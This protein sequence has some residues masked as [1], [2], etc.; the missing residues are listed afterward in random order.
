MPH[1]HRVL[2]PPIRTCH[3]A[4]M[5]PAG[6]AFVTYST[7]A[8]AEA[9]IEALNGT[10]TFPGAAQAIMVKLADAKPQDMQRVGAKRGM[11]DMMGG[12][13]GEVTSEGGRVLHPEHKT[14]LP[15]RWFEG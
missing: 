11:M 15:Q 5:L 1:A 4:S 12:G 7:W 2:Q 8:A 10:F 6:C 9:A 3:H 14:I 13:G